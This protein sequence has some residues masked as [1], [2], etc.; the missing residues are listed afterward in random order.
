MKKILV[1]T[2]KEKNGF[3]IKSEYNRNQLNDWFKNYSWFEIKPRPRKSKKRQAF[4]EV[5]VIPAWGQF[6][7]G[8]DP[9]LPENLLTA[10]NLFK[11][12]FHYVVM[13]DRDGNPRKLM[14]SLAGEHESVLEKYCEY[15][16]ANGAPVPN[17]D[18]FKKWR[19][20]YSQ[21]FRWSNFYDWLAFLELDVDSMPSKEVFNKITETQDE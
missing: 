14:Q 4:L 13:K 20:E 1:Q 16:E 17:V 3:S 8:L 5:A 2:N 6:N 19:D 21:D 15:A 9:R 7:Y 11:Q 12:D 18:L 10:R